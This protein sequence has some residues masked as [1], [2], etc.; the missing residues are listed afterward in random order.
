MTLHMIGIG[1]DDEKDISLKGL[2]RIKDSKYVFLEDYTSMLNRD[3]KSMEKLYDK[4][5]IKADREMVEKKAETEILAKA[6]DHDV[7]FLVVGDVFGA[8]THTDI[9]LRARKMGIRCTITH[10]ASIINAV[11]ETGLELY[12][13]GKTTSVPF[14]EGN[15]K[16]STAYNVISTNASN[17]MHTLVLLDIKRDKDRYMTIKEGID[18]LLEIEE[19]KQEKIFTPET[20]CVGCARLGSAE[21]KIIGGKAKDVKE[22]YFGKPLHC[23]IIPGNMHFMEEEMLNALK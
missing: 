4:E 20:F 3:L 8:T 11:S 12:K 16:P 6:R 2:E 17:G 15:F 10:N 22:E 19:E 1:L 9:F 23:L 14:P 18:I 21:A 7:S 5:V 13:F